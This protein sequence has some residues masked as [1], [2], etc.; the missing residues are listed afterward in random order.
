MVFDESGSSIKEYLLPTQFSVQYF[1]LHD[2]FYFAYRNSND[3]FFNI[4]RI[5]LE[6][7]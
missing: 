7:L 3:D 1:F 2:A 5:S 4:A 6:N